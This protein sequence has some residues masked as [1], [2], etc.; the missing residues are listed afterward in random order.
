MRAPLNTVEIPFAFNV[1]C[2]SAPH[3]FRL[4]ATFVSHLG[5]PT[6]RRSLRILQADNSTRLPRIPLDFQVFHIH[7][8]SQ[9]ESVFL[10]LY[11][12]YY[13]I[14]FEAA[15]NLWYLRGENNGIQMISQSFLSSV[16]W[17]TL[18]QLYHLGRCRHILLWFAYTF[19]MVR[20][21]T[22]HTTSQFLT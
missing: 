14:F 10:N 12:A 22:M 1:G 16:S 6:Y 3:T 15:W 19:V 8:S 17:R 21:K 7:H 4:I 13:F 2:Y 5:I 18:I 20:E 11:V 9:S